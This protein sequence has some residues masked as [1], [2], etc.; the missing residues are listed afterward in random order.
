M[1]A[2]I[3]HFLLIFLDRDEIP[4]LLRYPRF[5]MIE[6]HKHNRAAFFPPLKKLDRDYKVLHEF[7]QENFQ[8]SLKN[9]VQLYLKDKD[10]LLIE[11][12]RF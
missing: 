6:L 3:Q 11:T 8:A 2:L 9:F 5:C 4:E 10:A 1:Q 12:E 7:R